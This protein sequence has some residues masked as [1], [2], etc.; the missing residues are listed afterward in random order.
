[1][2]NAQADLYKRSIRCTIIEAALEY[3]I[4]MLVSGAYLARITGAL[5][6]LDSLTG[7]LSS[8]IS[9]SCLFQLGSVLLF[10]KRRSIKAPVVTC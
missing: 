10:G 3:F 4:S 1:M 8:F 7:A 2:Q 5:G 9:L 6:F